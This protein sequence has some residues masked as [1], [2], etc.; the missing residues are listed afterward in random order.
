MIKALHIDSQ[1]FAPAGHRLRQAHQSGYQQV[2]GLGVALGGALGDAT[3]RHWWGLSKYGG[4]WNMSWYT[5]IYLI[6]I[7]FTTI[8][9][10][11]T[12]DILGISWE[13][14]WGLVFQ[15]LFKLYNGL[16]S[17]AFSC[18]QSPVSRIE[19]EMNLF[20]Q[21]LT[22][23]YPAVGRILGNHSLSDGCRRHSP[24]VQLAHPAAS[25]W[26]QRCFHAAPQS[27]RNLRSIAEERVG[28]KCGSLRVLN[29]YWAARQTSS[30]DR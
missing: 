2:E 5:M 22:S 23:F 8:K 12:H 9:M 26:R 28:R 16:Q 19:E 21:F 1:S 13:I 7:D 18:I 24:G 20:K 17:I 6:L 11:I 25:R 27:V 4:Y 10:E 3:S 29:S 15:Y 14:K 30:C